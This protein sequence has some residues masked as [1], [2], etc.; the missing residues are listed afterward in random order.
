MINIF[1]EYLIYLD[2]LFNIVVSQSNAVIFLF[3]ALIFTILISK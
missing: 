1:N 2:E 3:I